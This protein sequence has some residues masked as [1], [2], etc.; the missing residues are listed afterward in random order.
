MCTYGLRNAGGGTRID[1]VGIP[2]GAAAVPGSATT[3]IDF[4]MPN[5]GDDHYPTVVRT[6][7]GVAG[8]PCTVKTRVATYDRNGWKDPEKLAVFDKLVWEIDWLPCNV[9]KPVRMMWW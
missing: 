7:V 2:V 9:E 6:H 4:V 8:S 1:F 5:E 3:W